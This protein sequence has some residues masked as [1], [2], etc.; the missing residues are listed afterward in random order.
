MPRLYFARLIL[1]PLQPRPEHRARR[2]PDQRTGMRQHFFLN[3]SRKNCFVVTVSMRALKVAS[4]NFY[5]F[6]LSLGV[7]IDRPSRKHRSTHLCAP[8]L[9]SKPN[10]LKKLS[11]YEESR[12]AP[13]KKACSVPP[14]EPACGP[15]NRLN[16][17]T[18][19]ARRGLALSRRKQGFESPRERQ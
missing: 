12:R 17:I 10:E 1:P 16:S 2:E 4:R 7:A 18:P 6:K 13:V 5:F 15:S 9:R 8:A 14:Q 3:V 11:E 19:L